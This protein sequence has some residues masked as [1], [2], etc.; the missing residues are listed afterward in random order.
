MKNENDIDIETFTLIN[1]I[2]FRKECRKTD[3]IT[4]CF[5]ELST[6]IDILTRLR[7]NG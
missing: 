3:A 5:L 6:G 4:D 7:K 2:S 1:V